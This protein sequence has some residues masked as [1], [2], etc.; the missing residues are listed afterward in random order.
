MIELLFFLGVVLILYTYLGYPVLLKL[1]PKAPVP[2]ATGVFTPGITVIIAA[3]KGAAAI[4]Q[5]LDNTLACDYP[6]DKIEVIVITDGSDDGTDEIVESYGDPRVVLIRQIPR[7]GK[8]AA[9][10]KG[11]DRSRNDILIF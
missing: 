10:K 4:R 11:V 2:E 7:A 1:M 8:T 9:Q 6:G 3:Y 5:K